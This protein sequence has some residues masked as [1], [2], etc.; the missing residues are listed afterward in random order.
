MQM[1][2]WF[3]LTWLTKIEHDEQTICSEYDNAVEPRDSECWQ[4]NVNWIFLNLLSNLS[5]VKAIA[6]CGQ[7][8][9]SSM[10]NVSNLWK[11]T[12]PTFSFPSTHWC[13]V[14]LSGFTHDVINF[15][16]CKRVE[17]KIA[18]WL[19]ALMSLFRQLKVWSWVE[20]SSKPP[21]YNS[22]LHV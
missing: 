8:C 11:H 21:F 22:L 17:T 3:W 14:G 18:G 13:H 16:I 5:L 2:R 4:W 1:H 6:R 7:Y 10:Q 12:A 20:T 9:W 19:I 15:S